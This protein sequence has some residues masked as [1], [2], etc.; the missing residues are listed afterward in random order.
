LLMFVRHLDL[1]SRTAAINRRDGEFLI[2]WDT[3]FDARGHGEIE[4]RELVRGVS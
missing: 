1:A 3:R 4:D 2:G